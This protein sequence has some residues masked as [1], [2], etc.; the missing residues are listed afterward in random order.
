VRYKNNNKIS[1]PQLKT[2]SPR[3][4]GSKYFA[5]L[6][7]Q[8]SKLSL[9]SL[10]QIFNQK[11]SYLP[12][13]IQKSKQKLSKVQGVNMDKEQKGKAAASETTAQ[14]PQ[15]AA[16]L[17]NLYYQVHSAKSSQK[18]TFLAVFLPLFC[19]FVSSLS[20]RLTRDSE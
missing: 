10:C 3:R 4:R 1:H 2:L 19:I 11:R 13:K 16:L 17:A 7:T 8:N 9:S 12:A 5:Q 18:N 14:P 6:T 20:P 15:N